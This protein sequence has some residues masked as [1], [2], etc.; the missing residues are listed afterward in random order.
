MV[1]PENFYRKLYALVQA[2]FRAAFEFGDNTKWKD[3]VTVLAIRKL[4]HSIH[5][6]HREVPYI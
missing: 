6:H 3:D 5:N 1:N 4:T 2:I